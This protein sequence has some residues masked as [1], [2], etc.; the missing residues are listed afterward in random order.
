MDIEKR[1]QRERVKVINQQQ[2][3][4]KEAGRVNVWDVTGRKR[5][6]IQRGKARGKVEKKSMGFTVVYCGK[7]GFSGISIK[8][9]EIMMIVNPMEKSITILNDYRDFYFSIYDWG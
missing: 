1:K 5:L 3:A 2:I 7:E 8:H 6:K 9:H 4:M